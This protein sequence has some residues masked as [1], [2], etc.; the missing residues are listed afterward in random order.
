[1]M[2]GIRNK[3]TVAEQIVCGML[4][5]AEISFELD[6]IIEK[7]KPDIVIPSSRTVILVHGCFWHA[8]ECHRFKWPDQNA[9]YWSSH[10]RDNRA[11]DNR[12]LLEYN[13]QNWKVLT[14]WECALIGKKKLINQQLL[15]DVKTFLG[16][17]QIQGIIGDN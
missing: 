15:L 14:V 11:R 17:N 1:M 9:A 4:S 12:N 6:W 8:H 13:K 7:K 3:G 5:D 10:L 2:S 16:N